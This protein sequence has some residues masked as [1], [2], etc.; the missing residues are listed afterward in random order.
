MPDFARLQGS[1]SDSAVLTGTVKMREGGPVPKGPCR[2]VVWAVYV[3][4]GQG[5]ALATLC[6]SPAMRPRA[7]GI[8]IAEGKIRGV[9]GSADGI[10]NP[11]DDILYHLIVQNVL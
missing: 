3:M 10:N 5:T 9:R 4:R 6:A 1:R 8:N 2:L 11:E 7:T